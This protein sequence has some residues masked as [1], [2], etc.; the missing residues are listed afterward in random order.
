MKKWL[1]MKQMGATILIV[2]LLLIGWTVFSPGM[3]KQEWW[4]LANEPT[5]M[6]ALTLLADSEN[7]VFETAWAR[8]PTEDELVELLGQNDTCTFDKKTSK[9]VVRIQDIF[10][11]TFDMDTWR[12][13]YL[14]KH[15]QSLS[16]T[17]DHWSTTWCIVATIH[18]DLISHMRIAL[19]Y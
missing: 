1:R 3:D 16:Y 2:A 15:L 19:W 17:T 13:F 10:K 11:K 12:G 8:I 6:E 9:T 5:T 14:L 4:D 18:D 7:L